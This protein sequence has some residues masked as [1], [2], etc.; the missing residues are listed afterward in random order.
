MSGKLEGI[1]PE[2]KCMCK[3]NYQYCPICNA[4]SKKEVSSWEVMGNK[5]GA[6]HVIIVCDEFSWENYPVYVHS[7][8]ELEEKL[9]EYSPYKNM[10]KVME[11]IPLQNANVIRSKKKVDNSSDAMPISTHHMK[12]R[13]NP[14]KPDRMTF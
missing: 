12:L 10:Q 14:K 2:P 11:V 9:R 4:T 7:K 3:Y 5:L 8:E 1:V 6:S 13:E